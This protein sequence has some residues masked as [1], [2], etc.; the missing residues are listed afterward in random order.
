MLTLPINLRDNA[1][2]PKLEFVL[3]DYHSQDGLGDWI[4]KHLMEHIESGRLVYAR[5]TEPEH[6]EMSHSRNVAFKLASG[7]I[8]CNVD[9]DNWT[10]PG[11][12]ARL[13]EVA[14]QQPERAIFTKS[15]QLIR[16]RM[17][18]YKHEWADLLGGYDEDM[19]HY[20]YD[21]MDLMHRGLLQGFTLMPFGG[22]YVDRIKTTK[23][24]KGQNMAVKNWRQTEKINE[25]LSLEKITRGELK[26]N[27]GRP[28]G[29]ARV[30]RNFTEEVIL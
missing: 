22:Q 25:A 16:G 2:Y 11:F 30:I 3:L 27:V 9:A 10:T 28:W 20:G 14:N 8:V 5:T 1:D 12:A 6:Y 24:A 26:S 4:G 15:R 23:E 29:A 7:E 21:D 13:N 17:A 19:H 18:F